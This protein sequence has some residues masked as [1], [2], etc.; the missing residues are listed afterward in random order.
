M[1]RSTGNRDADRD[2]THDTTWKECLTR[3]VLDKK[4]NIKGQLHLLVWNPRATNRQKDESEQE[5][6]W[7]TRL[8][9]G[10]HYCLRVRVKSK[11]CTAKEVYACGRRS[12]TY[13]T[14]S[15]ASKVEK[16][17]VKKN[18]SMTL[19]VHECVFSTT[20]T[21]KKSLLKQLLHNSVCGET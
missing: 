15:K 3:G 14:S 5:G 6:S 1:R 13:M 4:H 20:L 9:D 12:V 11:N 16:I 10:H 8:S 19:K 2:K 7:N 18:H 17:I 21:S